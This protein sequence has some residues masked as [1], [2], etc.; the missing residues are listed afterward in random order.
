MDINLN[1]LKYFYEVVKER[2][3]TKAAD[4]VF[5]TQPAMTRA[6]KDL[7]AQLNTKLLERSQKGV[8]PTSEGMILFNHIE[9]ILKEI[10]MTRD[11]IENSNDVSDFYIGTTTSNYF[12]LIIEIL[13]EFN[14]K[15]KDVRVHI[16]FE[17]I[18]VLDDL[19][20]SGKLDIVIKNKN[21]LLTDFKVLDEF[22]L[23]NFF[24]ASRKHYPELEGKRIELKSLLNNYPIV[25]MSDTSPGR[26][27]FNSFLREKGISYKP[28]YEFNSYDLCKKL[29]EAGIGIGIDNSSNFDD[30][31]YIHINTDKMPKRYFEFGY[32]ISSKHKYVDKFIEIYEKKKTGY[33]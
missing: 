16:V 12:N 11:I 24:V 27:S 32:N 28:T 22:E 14:T 33:N 19:R 9:N 5:I 31:N 30:K 18:D 3:I 20:K 23:E 7:E 4:K 26:R 25:I 1:L 13:K 2:N 17:S 21:D 8:V 6:I 10:N 29:V 15:Y